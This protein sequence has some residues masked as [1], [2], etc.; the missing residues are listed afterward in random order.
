ML[1]QVVLLLALSAIQQV[2]TDVVDDESVRAASA[3]RDSSSIAS[4][5]VKKDESRLSALRLPLPDQAPDSRA[6]DFDSI[7]T[8]NW[9]NFRSCGPN[10]LYAYLNLH[11][12]KVTLDAVNDLIQTDSNGATFDQLLAAAEKLGVPSEVV[13]VSPNQIASLSTPCIVHCVIE[14]STGHFLLFLGIA[15]D[16]QRLFNMADLVQCRI[17]YDNDGTVRRMASGY[18]LVPRRGM[19]RSLLAFVA[20]AITACTGGAVLWFRGSKT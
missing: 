9:R 11:G 8:S 17:N 7:E 4:S 13:F 14:G 3:S 2:S 5:S 12:Q 20:F 6:I 16:D 10:A 19:R 15:A 18:V 1:H